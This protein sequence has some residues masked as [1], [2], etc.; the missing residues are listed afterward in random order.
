MEQND[1]R[2]VGRSLAADRRKKTKTV[3]KKGEGDRG[4]QKPR[5]EKGIEVD[6]K[7]PICQL[8]RLLVL[9]FDRP[10]F[11]SAHPQL[12]A[13]GCGCLQSPLSARALS[14]PHQQI[15]LPTAISSTGIAPPS[16]RLVNLIQTAADYGV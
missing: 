16:A 6:F 8:A 11:L 9:A 14:Q 7:P 1:R 4:D 3:A 15:A 5:K 2:D 12:S 13:P 10:A